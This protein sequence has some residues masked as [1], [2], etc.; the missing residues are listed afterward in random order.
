MENTLAL[1]LASESRY[2]R[3]VKETI[4]SE[5][6]LFFSY[7]ISLQLLARFLPS[8]SQL[9]AFNKR[10]TIPKKNSWFPSLPRNLDSPKKKQKSGINFD[11]SRHSDWYFSGTT[12]L[13][14]SIGISIGTFLFKLEDWVEKLF[15]SILSLESW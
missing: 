10:Q 9:R 13:I 12:G 6:A 8:T 4:S 7:F 2:I 5:R 14:S 1:S 3:N 15:I 11:S